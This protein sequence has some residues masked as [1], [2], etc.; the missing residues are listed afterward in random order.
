MHHRRFSRKWAIAAFLV[1][2]VAGSTIAYRSLPRQPVFRFDNYGEMFDN[3]AEHEVSELLARK[4]ARGTPI[5]DVQRFLESAGAKC[6]VL[7]DYPDFVYCTYDHRA[8]GL[9]GIFIL[10]EWKVLVWREDQDYVSKIE[11]HRYLTGP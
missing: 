4:F 7:V 8:A 3:N 9:R 10:V 2:L 1:L 11:V 6:S 5:R